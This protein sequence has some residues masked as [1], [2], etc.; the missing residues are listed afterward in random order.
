MQSSETLL[1]RMLK[2]LSEDLSSIK[3]TQPETKN[4]LIII[5]NNLQGS[6]SRVDEAGNRIN[7][8]EHKE[9]KNYHTEQ[10]AEKIIQ[11]TRVV[12]RACGTTS[13]VP[14]FA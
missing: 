11:K 10:E 5:K 4:T 9:A 1:I 6:N 7:D 14:T 2:E 13:S 3:M 12:Q 8:L